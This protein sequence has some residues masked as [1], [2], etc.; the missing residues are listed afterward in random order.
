MSTPEDSVFDTYRDRVERPLYRLFS[1][2]GLSEWRYFAGGMAANVVARAASLLP[3]LLLG[4]AIDSVFTSESAF[5]LP[6][7]PASWLP[8]TAPDAAQ[9]QFAAVAIAVS[10]FVTAVFTWLYGVAA[11]LFAHRVMHAVR[12]DSFEK[13]QRLD[14]TFFDDKQTGEVMSV[15]NNDASNLEVFLDNALQNTARLAVMVVGIAGIMFWMN[16][17]LAIVTLAAIPLIV[18][19]TLWFMRA[20]EP[21]YVAQRQSIGDLNTR[22]EN[23]LSGVE[24]VKT[25]NTEAYETARVRDASYSFFRDTMSVLKL[26][27]L[28]RPGMELLAG[29]S[30]AVTFVVGGIWLFQGPPLFFSGTLSTGE[31]VTFILLTQRF[32]TP[33][34]EV[35]NIV[36]QYENAKASSERVFGLRDIPVRI[37][38]DADATDIS[39]VEGRVEYDDVTFGYESDPYGDPGD[40]T[41]GSLADEDVIL[42]GVSFDADPG[43]T[44]ALVGPTGAGK[45][46]ILKLLLRLYDVDG[47]EIRV[48]GHDIRDVTLESLRGAIG[49]VGQDTFL[50]DGTIAENIT[51]GEFD[52]D[53]EDVVEAA[54]AAEAHEFITEMPDGYDTRVGERGV[55]LSGGQRQRVSIARTVLHDPQILLLDEATSAVDTETEFLIQRSLDRLS[56]DRTTFS[57][58]HRLSTVKNADQILVVE[59]GEIAERGTHGEL[60]DAEGVYAALWDAQ[61]GDRDRLKRELDVE[62]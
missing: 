58:A 3:P 56:E 33:L 22:L 5:S 10:F 25:S 36:D 6:V 43:E 16:W 62:T 35:S 9:F 8:A 53:R 59:A 41:P 20:V 21:R 15:L 60:L 12:T 46:T 29:L 4:T 52:A 23:A 47:G 27:Y 51:Y 28:Y 44:T 14:M 26:N 39:P 50:F 37:Q 49:Y 24:L 30:F 48:D 19:L 2:Y 55:K 13:M 1:E 40:D 38:D 61:T 57:I 42:D 31:F 32:V 7:V 17:Q 34:A 45:S 11:N 18:V 54:K